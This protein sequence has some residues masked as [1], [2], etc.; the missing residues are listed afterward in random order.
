MYVYV[1]VFVFMFVFVFVLIN[2]TNHLQGTLEECWPIATA[3]AKVGFVLSITVQPHNPSLIAQITVNERMSQKLKQWK[4]SETKPKYLIAQ[5]TT[6][7]LTNLD[8]FLK[9]TK[10]TQ[11]IISFVEEFVYLLRILLK[12]D[13]WKPLIQQKMHQS[14]NA[15]PELVLKMERNPQRQFILNRALASLF[16]I[17]SWPENMLH[18]GG[19]A[20]VQITP[21]LLRKALIL[22]YTHIGNEAR[23]VF[24]PEEE[25]RLDYN[26][27]QSNNTNRQLLIQSVDPSLLQ[28]I[29]EVCF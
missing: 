17:S 18:T 23:I 1:F 29:P 9:Q 12:S 20:N 24:L 28:P 19:L 15:L 8:P 3:L 11:Y 27:K 25:N 26:N 21:E 6:P 2:Q 13:P 7:D 5:Q 16:I 14:L 4:Q 10:T 22:S